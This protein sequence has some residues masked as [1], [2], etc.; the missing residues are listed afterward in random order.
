M[1]EKTGQLR[2][3]RADAQRNVDAL[4]E[5][6]RT[7]FDTTGVGAPAKEITDLAGVGVG[8]LYRHFPLRSDLVKAV[9]ESGIDAVVAAGPELS[10]AHAPAEA[11]TA[12]LRRYTQLLGTKRGLAP[13]LHSG[14]PAYEGLADYFM[15]KAG[16]VL[17]GLLDSAA[18][19]GAVRDDISAPDLLYAVANLCIPVPGRGFDYNQRMVALLTDGLRTARHRTA[20]P[21]PQR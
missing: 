7:V 8:T 20:P 3:V 5:A 19:D 21:A 16:P 9:V 6:A 11:L 17:A 2:R 18:A 13:A 1:S 4:V 10:A 12:W 15:E 14:D